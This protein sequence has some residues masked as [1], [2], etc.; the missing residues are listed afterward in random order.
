MFIPDKQRQLWNKTR[1]KFRKTLPA[2]KR[3]SG[4]PWLANVT[5]MKVQGKTAFLSP[6]P[7]LLVTKCVSIGPMWGGEC[8]YTKQFSDTSW[9]SHSLEISSNLYTQCGA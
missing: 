1:V 5:A 9:V 4:L 7:T 6:L 8:S 2:G 3:W